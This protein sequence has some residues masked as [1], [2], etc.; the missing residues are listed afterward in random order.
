MVKQ[1]GRGFILCTSYYFVQ[2]VLMYH[3]LMKVSI[4]SPRC[5]SSYPQ[6]SAHHFVDVS[7][8][9]YPSRSKARVSFPFPSTNHPSTSSHMKSVGYRPCDPAEGS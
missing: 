9:L 8:L 1:G 3:M 2:F 4:F 5:I 6:K 7:Q